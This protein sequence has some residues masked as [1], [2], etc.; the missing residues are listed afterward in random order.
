DVLI[1][2]VDVRRGGLE[3]Y[4][5]LV[6]ATVLAPLWL[7]FRER[8]SVRWY[9]DI[10]APSVALGLA[11]GRIG[12]FL[13]GCCYGG[14]CALPWAVTLPA[15]SPAAVTQWQRELPGAGLPDPLTV[16]L[17]GKTEPLPR[18]CFMV[19]DEEIAVAQQHVLPVLEIQDELARATDAAQRR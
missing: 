5:G 16:K 11:I 9:Q 10:V 6:L 2:I 15:G 18:E 8:V 4:G 14:V 7:K 19:S 17:R 3:F 12:C 1:G 13:N